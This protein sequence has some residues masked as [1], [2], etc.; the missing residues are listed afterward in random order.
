MKKFLL[1]FALIISVAASAQTRQGMSSFGLN[2]GYGFD[3]KNAVIGLDYRY[4]FTDEIRLAPSLSCFVKNDGL[5]ACAIDVNAH[6]LFQLS[7]M[8][9]FY[10][11]AGLDLSF[12]K[13]HYTDNLSSTWTRLGVNVGMGVELYATQTIT[14]GL[15]AKYTIVKT[16]DQAILGVRVGY[17]F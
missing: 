1:F 17:N 5:S 4:S 11:L 2:V 3:S 12:W 14:V 10:P 8:I 9:G 6:Y 13:A 7:D 15:E 16:F